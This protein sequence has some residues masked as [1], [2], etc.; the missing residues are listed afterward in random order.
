MEGN[1]TSLDLLY[2]TAVAPHVYHPRAQMRYTNPFLQDSFGVFNSSSLTS[3]NVIFKDTK[4]DFLPT[5]AGR[6][7][8]NIPVST[9]FMKD[10]F[11][12]LLSPIRITL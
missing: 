9:L 3:Q 12:T 4:T 10:V 1:F 2:P 8:E 7:K 11:P 5:E 6:S